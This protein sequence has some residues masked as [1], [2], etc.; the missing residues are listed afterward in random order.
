MPP[1]SNILIGVSG[2]KDSSS[3]LY[4]LYQLVYVR[5]RNLYADKNVNLYMCAVDEGIKGYRTPSL[6]V[7]Y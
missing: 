4:C 5:Y 2:G 1:G 3:L 7:V 6:N